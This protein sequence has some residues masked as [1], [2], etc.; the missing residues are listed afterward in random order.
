MIHYYKFRCIF[1]AIFPSFAM[2]PR[3]HYFLVWE[4]DGIKQNVSLNCLGFFVMKQQ[5]VYAIFDAIF[6]MGH[7]ETVS[8]YCNTEVRLRTSDPLPHRKWEPL[9]HWGNDEEKNWMPCLIYYLK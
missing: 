2:N 9:R 8:L 1:D 5:S 7:P 3:T 6:T 4:Y